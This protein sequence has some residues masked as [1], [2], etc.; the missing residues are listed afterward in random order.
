MNNKNKGFGAIVIVIIVVV[1]AISGLIG[2]KV[3]DVYFN[4]KTVNTTQSKQ[5]NSTPTTT[6][7][8]NAVPEIV[9]NTDLE[10]AEKTLDSENIEGQQTT[11]LDA[12]TNF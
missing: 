3:W 4:K 7:A 9:N 11:Q 5:I 8:T 6:G 2:W 1:I 10:N 12:E